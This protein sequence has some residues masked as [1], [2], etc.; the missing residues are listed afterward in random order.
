MTVLLFDGLME[1][2][3]E[4]RE[5]STNRWQ[6]RYIDGG[7]PNL[8][9]D[10]F[11][12]R[13]EMFEWIDRTCHRKAGLPIIP[14]DPKRRKPSEIEPEPVLTDSERYE[15]AVEEQRQGGKTP[16]GCTVLTWRPRGLG[17]RS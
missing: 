17:G 3:I 8:Q 11:A 14:F 16:S 1:R 9:S 7:L 6:A 15:Q 2:A 4:Y 13:H 5:C 10:H 12:T